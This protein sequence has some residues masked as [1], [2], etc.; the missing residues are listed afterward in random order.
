MIAGRLIRPCSKLASVRVWRSTTL[1]DELGVE[2][3]TVD[4]LYAALDWLLAR[5]KRIETKLARRHLVEIPYRRTAQ[6]SPRLALHFEKKTRF[7]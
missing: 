3:A 4:E 7:S 6:G 2:D 5:K 1:A